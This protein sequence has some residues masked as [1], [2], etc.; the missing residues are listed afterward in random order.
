MSYIKDVSENKHKRFYNM[1]RAIF[2]TPYVKHTVRKL[3]YFPS[4]CYS[5]FIAELIEKVVPSEFIISVSLPKYNN[6]F[7]NEKVIVSPKQTVL[8]LSSLKTYGETWLLRLS[9][10]FVVVQ[11]LFFILFKTTKEDVIIVYHVPYVSFLINLI[12]KFIRGKLIFVV[13][14]IYSAVYGKS[15]RAIQNE[16]NKLLNADGYI[17]TNDH[18]KSYFNTRNSV[19]IYGDYRSYQGKQL[20]EVKN[21]AIN[22]VYAGKI[23]SEYVKDAFLAVE[24]AKYL[25]SKYHVYILGYGTQDD[26]LKLQNRILEIN[27]SKGFDIVTYEGRLEGDEYQQFLEKCSI[28]LCTRVLN[29]KES[30]Y[31]FPSKLAVYL[32]HGIIPVCPKLSIFTVSSLKGALRFVESELTPKNVADVIEQI[33]IKEDQK[34]I[35]MEFIYNL[36]SKTL[37]SIADMLNIFS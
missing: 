6:Y 20:N 1:K 24:T 13:A 31:C 30:S 22:V 26:I 23:D 8:F 32:S 34:Q 21:D 10:L 27:K 33:N 14:E 16:I 5:E 19:V 29:E 3:D 4:I 25:S 35:N 17:F 2:I 7:R 12:R 37:K 11:L 28:G 15:E 18:L 9:Q 36:K